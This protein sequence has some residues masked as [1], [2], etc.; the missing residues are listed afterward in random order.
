MVGQISLGASAGFNVAS[1]AISA[2]HG[3]W[4]NAGIQSLLVVAVVLAAWW[5][6]YLNRWTELSLEE[7]TARRDFARSMADKAAAATEAFVSVGTDTSA[8]KH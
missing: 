3:N 5:S 7:L 8:T 2:I 4:A 6:Y 1:T